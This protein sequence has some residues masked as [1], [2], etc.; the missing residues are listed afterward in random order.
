MGASPKITI[1]STYGIPDR[2]SDAAAAREYKSA[3]RVRTP[4]WQRLISLGALGGV[5][6][7]IGIAL[8]LSLIGLG[9][10]TLMLLEAAIG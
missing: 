3:W 7:A 4:I 1:D 10:V 9:V 5:A 6:G 8:A 2:L